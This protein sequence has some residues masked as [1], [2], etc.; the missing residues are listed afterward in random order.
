MTSNSAVS[1]SEN[2]ETYTDASDDEADARADHY[3]SA[4][5]AKRET[6]EDGYDSVVQNSGV[7]K[8]VKG[9]G[10]GVGGGGL[11]IVGRP[12]HAIA[13]EGISGEGSEAGWTD[14]G[15]NGETF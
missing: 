3:T 12:Q 14:D 11:R 6:P 2:W 15:D 5:L 1:G 9:Y 13:E 10:L 7:G 8:K 4:R